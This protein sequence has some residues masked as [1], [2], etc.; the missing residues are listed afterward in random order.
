[1]SREEL[2]QAVGFVQFFAALGAGA[3]VIWMVDAVV[4]SPMT[5]V[6]ANAQNQLVIE[7]QQWFSILIE[8]LP[9]VFLMIAALGGI[10][11]AVFQTEFA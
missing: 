5:Y 10:S 2:H 3:V 11:W 9:I 1:M 6:S 8:N 4:E 7:S